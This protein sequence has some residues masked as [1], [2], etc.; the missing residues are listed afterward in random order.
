MKCHELDVIVESTSAHH[1]IAKV[2]DIFLAASDLNEKKKK[3][4]KNSTTKCKL[5]IFICLS[6]TVS[7]NH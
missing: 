5:G 6:Q 4:K 3:T 7:K 1:L 2:E